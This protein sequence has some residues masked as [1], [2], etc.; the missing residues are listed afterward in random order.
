M[1]RDVN[2]SDSKCCENA[3]VGK[4]GLID[5]YIY[6]IVN[7]SYHAICKLSGN[8]R[9]FVTYLFQSCNLQIIWTYI[10][11]Y[12]WFSVDFFWEIDWWRNRQFAKLSDDF[13]KNKMFRWKKND[14]FY[15][16]PGLCVSL[17]FF[18]KD[19]QKPALENCLKIQI[20][21]KYTFIFIFFIFKK[22]FFVLKS[23]ETIYKL[24]EIFV[25]L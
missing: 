12:F 3:T 15:R 25:N 9:Q 14:F 22:F 17:Y 18:L 8:F 10:V 23:S 1:P 21:R 16:L 11:R 19:A 20:V 4:N 7:L 6:A 5:P 13:K 24:S 2:L